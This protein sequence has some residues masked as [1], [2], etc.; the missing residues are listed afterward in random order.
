MG[1]GAAWNQGRDFTPVRKWGEGRDRW[2]RRAFG[3]FHWQF[4]PPC[5]LQKS[6]S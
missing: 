3:K 5:S 2:G 1:R 6:F 4:L